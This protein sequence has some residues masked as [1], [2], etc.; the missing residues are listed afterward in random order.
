MSELSLM[1]SILR[2][3]RVGWWCIQKHIYDFDFLLFLIEKTENDVVGGKLKGLQ[4]S[5]NIVT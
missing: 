4:L 2:D 1:L 3:L 5:A